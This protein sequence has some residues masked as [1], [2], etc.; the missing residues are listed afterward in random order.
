M[1]FDFTSH[2]YGLPV[3]H[4]A[5]VRPAFHR[6]QRSRAKRVI[7]RRNYRDTLHPSIRR[8]HYIQRHIAGLTTRP[9]Y[10][11][12]NGRN[13]THPE[14]LHGLCIYLQ[15]CRGA[16]SGHAQ[17]QRKTTH[18]H[19]HRSHAHPPERNTSRILPP[20]AAGVTNFP[21]WCPVRPSS[22]PCSLIPVHCYLSCYPLP[23]TLY[24]V[25]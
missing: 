9:L 18:G 3:Q 15:R 10:R 6:L 2:A 24:P 16:L 11:R 14:P 8:Q 23:R 20:P 25:F 13:G 22:Q 7:G 19:P 12:I 5:L 21:R 1:H 4:V 17:R